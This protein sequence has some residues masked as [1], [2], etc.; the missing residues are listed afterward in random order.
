MRQG[1][2][3]EDM[4]ARNARMEAETNVTPTAATAVLFTAP[5]PILDLV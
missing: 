3:L 5:Q 2:Q 4:A 1:H